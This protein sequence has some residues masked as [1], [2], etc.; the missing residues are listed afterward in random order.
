MC[1]GLIGRAMNSSS[2][3]LSIEKKPK[4]IRNC[5]NKENCEVTLTVRKKLVPMN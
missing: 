5:F 1:I 2:I 4:H 3:Y